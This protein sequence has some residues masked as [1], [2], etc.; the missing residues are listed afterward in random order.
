MQAFEA[1]SLQKGSNGSIQPV[2][3]DVNGMYQLKRAHHLDNTR[4][5]DIVSLT[6]IQTDVEVAPKFGREASK[7]LKSNNVMEKSQSFQL[8]HFCD[9]EIFYMFHTFNR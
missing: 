8:N 6:S 4:I 1:T 9:R 3:N 7:E 2:P 5:G